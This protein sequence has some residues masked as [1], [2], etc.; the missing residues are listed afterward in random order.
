V[1]V[2]GESQAPFG[3]RVVT[4]IVG[5]MDAQKAKQLKALLGSL[6][7]PV[8]ARL[9]KAV[10]VD[11]LSGGTALPH[12]LILEAVRPSL[13]RTQASDRTPTPLRLFCRPFEDLL[14]LEPRKE[15]TKGRIARSS[16]A[17]VWNWLSQK[18]ASD[19]TSEFALG[20]KTAA[21]GPNSSLAVDRA[22]AFWGVASEALSAALDSE[23]NRKAA[24]AILGDDLIVADACEMS[25]LLSIGSDIVDVQAMLPLHTPS[26]TE[27]V[28][29]K[30]REIYDRVVLSVPDAASYIAVVAMNRLDRPWE[31]LKLPLHVSRQTQDTL[32]SN[33]DMGMV[34]EI[35]FADIEMHGTY[36][37]TAQPKTFDADA[38]IGHVAGFTTLS[39]GIV[40]GID[41]RRDGKWGQRLLKD[42][43]TVGGIMDGF[44]E[45]AAKEVQSALPTIKS[46]SYAGGPRVPDLSHAPDAE[47]S[48]R[49][50][51]Y[52]RL[53]SGCRAFA[54][55]GSF[56]ASNKNAIDD[57]QAAL[58]RYNEDLLKELR[59]ADGARHEIVEQFFALSVNMTE[60][61]FSL[62]EAE[63]LRRR[64]RAASPAVAA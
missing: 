24:R 40:K 7:V 38:L 50:M 36:I 11:R 51:N 34:G 28:I 49:A 61:A 30:L 46:G 56:G 63:I 41:M 3:R 27:D 13:R 18:L 57:I 44:M 15:K 54:A 2:P 10:E 64:G 62:E 31:A 22:K 33:T 42:R 12:E 52:L 8:A 9:A 17:P 47:K 53:V 5:V 21:I 1:T 60:F 59:T 16:I 32:I 37:R 48:D 58:K 4:W 14:T 23:K 6:P 55:A 39:S 20:V 26:L 25:L 29:W 43:A 19:A 45:R 35:L